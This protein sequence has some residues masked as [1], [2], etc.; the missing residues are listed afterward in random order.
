MIKPVKI[1]PIITSDSSSKS[2]KCIPICSKLVYNQGYR[3]IPKDSGTLGDLH[4]IIEKLFDK[5]KR[6]SNGQIVFCLDYET[7]KFVCRT[8]DKLIEEEEYG[9]L[10]K[11]ER[12]V[13]CCPLHYLASKSYKTGEN[14]IIKLINQVD[15]GQVKHSDL[16]DFYYI[17]FDTLKQE[18][19]KLQFYNDIYSAALQWFRRIKIVHLHGIPS[20][21]L[22]KLH[23]EE[24][25]E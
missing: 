1:H 3:T 9:L 20:Q 5:E 10:D 21:A 7:S 25:Y 17:Y 24:M 13:I 15:M 4:D 19:R 2:A 11:Y 18:K 16:Q 6:N 22:E 23:R 8:L 12:V 14:K